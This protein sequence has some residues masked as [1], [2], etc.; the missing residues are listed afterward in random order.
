MSDLTELRVKI[1]A[2]DTEILRLLNERATVA[3][4]IGI[5]KNRA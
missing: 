5:I 1:D 3:K 4:E 2:L